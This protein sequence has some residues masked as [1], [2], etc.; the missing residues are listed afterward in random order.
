MSLN[1]LSRMKL[2]LGL[3]KNSVLLC[4]VL[5]LLT[6]PDINANLQGRWV[7]HPAATLRTDAKVKDGQIDRI[8]D[9]NRYVY[10]SVRGGAF[11]RSNPYF[12][13]TVKDSEPLQLFRYDKTLPWN[14]DCIVPMASEADLSGGFY[15]ALNYS[16]SEGVLGIAYDNGLLDFIFDNGTVVK[17]NALFDAS[18]PRGALEVYSITFDG[19]KPV[20]YIATSLGV[21]VVDIHN[22][23]LIKFHSTDKKVSWAARVGEN[24]VLFAGEVSPK[25]YSTLTYV[26]PEDAIPRTL[27]SPVASGD[28]LQALMPLTDKS[29]AAMAPGASDTQ[30]AVNVYTIS[31]SRLES[32]S[33]IPAS[34]VNA[35]ATSDFR[36]L[37]RTDGLVAPS[38]DGYTVVTNNS[39]NIIKRGVEVD[40]SA[41]D[42][43]AEFKEKAL[44]VISKD[45]L[46]ATEKTVKAMTADGN[47]VWFFTNAS[48]GLDGAKRGFYSRKVSSGAWESPSSITTP[49]GPSNTYA[50]YGEWNPKHG[51]L[52]RGPTSFY[53]PGTGERDYFFSYKDGKW[54]DLSY[55]SKNSLYDPPTVNAKYVVADPINPDWIWSNP[56][57]TGLLR[58][59]LSD[60][61][62]VFMLGNSALNWETAYPGFHKYFENQPYVYN[63]LTSLSNVDFDNEGRMWFGRYYFAPD[64]IYD[65]EDITMASI[66][67]YYYTREERE[68]LSG[69]NFVKPHEL[70]IKETAT[71]HTSSLLAL[72]APANENLIMVVPLTF[73]S[74]DK[75]SAVYD[76]KGTLDNTSDDVTSLFYDLNDENGEVF[77]YRERLF[78]YEDEKTGDVWYCTTSGPIIIKPTD[79]ISGNLT[80]RRPR[81]SRNC[82]VAVDENPFEQVGIKGIS[83]DPQGRMWLA[84]EVGLYCLS[85]DGQEL[86]GFYNMENSPLP[87][88]E[89]VSVACDMSNGSVFVMTAKGMA[90]FQ[91]EGST[92]SVAPGAHLNIWPSSVTPDYVGYLSIT[93]AEEGSEYVVVNSDGETLVSLGMPQGGSL[94]WDVRNSA[95]ERLEAGR[96]NIKRKTVDE[97]HPII[98]LDE[99]KVR[100]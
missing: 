18:T 75:L 84:S 70:E 86:L 99:D 92:V 67:L 96:Y 30:Q 41:S 61:S 43:A 56:V 72:K 15:T 31:G 89:L 13:T 33:I 83:K 68:S 1:K 27:T 93:G 2:N 91:P 53:D 10:F 82:G 4:S 38:K 40:L 42:P 46:D 66:P 69:G 50:T 57:K 77:T 28:N 95:G 73:Y 63:L 65:Y 100:R 64:H 97:S 5:S 85:A 51:M 55:A 29:F 39:L 11:Q 88:D 7:M 25:G 48:S 81:I 45:G 87:T 26:Y 21:A 14:D 22:G 37:F 3:R 76:H 19:L 60:F 74:Y 59:N 20:V 47:E 32:I 58:V 9:G 78:V 36:H 44:T 8:I 17:S 79:I 62:D 80:G 24:M 98:I 16:P 52:F 71:Y 90:E 6:I 94:Q 23:E 49:S 34:E 12:Y 35:G 54:T